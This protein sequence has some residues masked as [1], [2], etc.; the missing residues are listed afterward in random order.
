MKNIYPTNSD[1]NIDSSTK[2][3][4]PKTFDGF[5]SELNHIIS[6]CRTKK[7]LVLFRGQRKR[8]WLLDST[9]VR[10]CKAALFGLSPEVRLSSMITGSMELHRVFLN[11]LLL[12][13]GVL[14][15]PTAELEALSTNEGIDAW[16]ELMKRHQQYQ[17]EDPSLLKGSNLLDWT[18]SPEVALYFANYKRSGDGAVYICDATGTGKTQPNI[19]VGKIL[20][21]MNKVGNAGKTLGSPLLFCPQKQILCERARNQQAIYFAQMDMR[22]DLETHWRLCEK[23][24]G[25]VTILIKLILPSGSE[26]A[27]TEYLSYRGITDA[28]IYPGV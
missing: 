1:T 17:N 18:Q 24:L 28:F 26:K 16:F 11:L 9:F 10:S 4:I 23:D 19:S 12:K 14:M 2:E 7:S 21:L 25:D 13:Y 22:T 3:W 15:R 8:E 27:V 5:L 6:S 20:D